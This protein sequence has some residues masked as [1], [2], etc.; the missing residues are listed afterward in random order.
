MPY[1]QM[2]GSCPAASAVSFCSNELCSKILFLRTNFLKYTDAP[3]CWLT[4]AD[5]QE[6]PALRLCRARNPRKT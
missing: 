4:E 3:A 1:K 2:G 6:A 5:S